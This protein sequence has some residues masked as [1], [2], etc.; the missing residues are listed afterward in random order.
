M[1]LIR[2]TD[3]TFEATA[4]PFLLSPILTNG[5]NSTNST[6]STSNSTTTP[7]RIFTGS[8]VTPFWD[9]LTEDSL[10]YYRSIILL[11]M[12]GLGFLNFQL[13]STKKLSYCKHLQNTSYISN[14]L[15]IT[16]LWLASIT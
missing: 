12:A 1:D 6:N 5:T 11:M 7:T 10:I 13:V 15:A 3:F 14:I 4:H 16:L 2:N 9:F 8:A